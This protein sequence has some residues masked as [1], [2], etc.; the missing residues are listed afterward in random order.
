MSQPGN[1]GPMP[2]QQTALFADAV[3]SELACVLED[4]GF[5]QSRRVSELL[6]F[7][8]EAFLLGQTDQLKESVIGVHVFGR[9]PGYDVKSDPIVRVTAGRV[10]QKLEDYYRGQGRQSPVHIALPKGGY[11]PEVHRSPASTRRAAAVPGVR[12][13]NRRTAATGLVIVITMAGAWWYFGRDT[14]LSPAPM[15]RVTFD[16]GQNSGPT[17]SPDGRLFAFASDRSRE[18]HSDIWLKEVRTGEPVRLTHDGSNDYEPDFSPDGTLISFRSDRDGGG[19]YTVPVRGGTETLI[20]ARGHRPKFSP[21]GESIAYSTGAWESYVVPTSGG[22]PSRI[23]PSFSIVYAPTW[24]GR[25]RRLLFWGK[26]DLD[27]SPSS[28]PDWWIWN[29][30]TDSVIRTGAIDVLRQHQLGGV[31]GMR[32]LPG[33]WSDERHVVVFSAISRDSTDLWE[34]PFD[35]QAEKVA[36]APRRLTYLNSGSGLDLLP[37]RGPQGGI[38]FT[39]A[40]SQIAVYRVPLHA[41]RAGT[42]EAWD[43]VAPGAYSPSVT[44]DDGRMAYSRMERSANWDV[45]LKN[46]RDGHEIPVAVGAE[47]EQSS[48]ISADGDKVAYAIRPGSRIRVWSKGQSQ[49]ETVCDRCLDPLDW[50]SDGQYLLFSCAREHDHGFAIG[51]TNLRGAREH[52][53]IYEALN[54]DVSGARISP[55]SKWVAFTLRRHDGEEL[56]AAPFRGTLR[57]PE[58]EWLPLTDDRRPKSVIGW[59]PDGSLLYFLSN[60]DGFSCLWAMKTDSPRGAPVEVCALHRAISSPLLA[61][62]VFGAAVTR[63]YFYF[64]MG[65]MRGDIWLMNRTEEPKKDLRRR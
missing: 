50:S 10:R 55:D 54:S 44:A 4:P 6:R 13:L 60:R 2:E 14:N 19:I 29:P 51:V 39:N 34:L 28:D 11:K 47:R 24:M 57:V 36:G 8:V 42:R 35:A 48:A 22:T 56:F 30:E 33:F 49:S 61:P 32:V 43:R 37:A 3:R 31:L 23:Q 65:D 25:T 38:L 5:R 64:T 26:R 58:G 45:W 21:D 20:A 9:V 15:A 46:L 52:R 59:S 63:S 16:D 1:P 12:S 62:G 27:Q 53:T 17:L 40:S 18:G 7:I 41:K